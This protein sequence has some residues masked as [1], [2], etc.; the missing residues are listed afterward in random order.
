MS[1]LAF[2]CLNKYT[3]V[4]MLCLLTWLTDISCPASHTHQ[5]CQVDMARV[6][7]C[8]NTEKGN[9]SI[10]ALSTAEPE[11]KKNG[12][13]DREGRGREIDG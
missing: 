7:W 1:C 6:T 5:S 12:G 4:E 10:L 11:R 9:G 8:I 2:V 3:A 13:S